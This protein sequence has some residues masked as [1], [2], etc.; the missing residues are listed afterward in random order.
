MKG[1]DVISSVKSALVLS[2]F[3]C[4]SQMTAATSITALS[5]LHNFYTRLRSIRMCYPCDQSK[6]A[7][8]YD[9][10][11]F[12]KYDWCYICMCSGNV[13]CC[14]GSDDCAHDVE[15]DGITICLLTGRILSADNLDD[16]A[17]RRFKDDTG[18]D[19]DETDSSKGISST[20]NS[21]FQDTEMEPREK[22]EVKV[23][24]S[25]ESET[26]E[27]FKERIMQ[28][29]QLQRVSAVWSDLCD[30]FVLDKRT[31]ERY[32]PTVK[33]LWLLYQMAK[34]RWQ[35]QAI[36]PH[37]FVV[38]V[39]YGVLRVSMAVDQVIRIDSICSRFKA[40][41]GA[42]FTLTLTR[43]GVDVGLSAVE[44]MELNIRALGAARATANATHTANV[45]NDAIRSD[46]AAKFAKEKTLRIAMK[47]ATNAVP[48]IQRALGRITSA[49]ERTRLGTR[50]SELEGLTVDCK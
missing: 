48:A 50:F 35:L 7:C 30:Q 17:K 41:P 2:D 46:I 9:R 18:R 43:P 16:R 10:C 22:I 3:Q 45:L 26:D 12:V 38:A 39:V 25:I 28:I 4:P 32:A 37:D 8:R 13:H 15:E 11:L 14:T 44:S 47:T 20:M 34:E 49:E 40:P 27:Q 36:K 29:A 23:A 5:V 21:S 33:S 1:V 24:A 6:H 31:K 19:E 42:V